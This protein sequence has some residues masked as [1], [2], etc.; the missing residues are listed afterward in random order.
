MLDNLF[1]CIG[2]QK[3]GTSWLH[4]VMSTDSR[5][6]YCPFVKEIHYFD[7]L[8]CRS[9]HLN[10]WRAHHL[11]N[12]VARNQ[13]EM[14]P[15]LSNWLSEQDDLAGNWKPKIGKERQMHKRF[16]H[17]TDPVN[18][19]WYEALLTARGTK[20]F[21]MDITP[22]YAVIGEAGFRHL[23]RMAKNVKVLFVMREPVARCWSG[24]LQGKKNKPGGL[25]SFA[26]NEMSDTDHLFEV[27]TT[28]K[29][30]GARSDYL[31]TLADLKSAGLLEQCQI[32]FYDEVV[33]QPKAFLVDL[34]R[35]LDLP[36]PQENSE[37]EKAIFT[38]VYETAGKLAIPEALESRLI[39]H[40]RGEIAKLD[41]LLPV[42]KAW[43]NRSV[44]HA[45]L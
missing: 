15:L 24:V 42:P 29:D 3:S 11:I 30:V 19:Q 39:E 22:D 31:A 10:N 20:E 9:K 33:N 41:Q 6:S 23:K 37:F 40:Y 7:Y 5:F 14:K 4:A 36:Y 38:R 34:Y 1:V 18:D 25:E 13:M 28:G 21:A 44:S 26:L 32:R 16:S 17:L 27:C 8:Y 35:F 2:A 45:A 12:M 43:K